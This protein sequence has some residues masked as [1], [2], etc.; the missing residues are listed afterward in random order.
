MSAPQPL[1]GM[2]Q[3]SGHDI[4][5][6]PTLPTLSPRDI[7]RRRSPSRHDASLFNARRPS[8]NENMSSR[9]HVSR[10]YSPKVLWEQFYATRHANV[11][12]TPNDVCRF[13]HC[14]F[15]P[16]P[17]ARAF[18]CLYATACRA[19]SCRPRCLFAFSPARLPKAR[20]N[21]CLLPLSFSLVCLRPRLLH[22][23]RK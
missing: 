5:E 8:R 10:S 12:H 7:C 22:A 16:S 20:H 11:A 2:P 17:A 3:T 14:A 18:C 23:S 6:S 4:E 1:T 21:M 13:V 19:T 9:W 15:F